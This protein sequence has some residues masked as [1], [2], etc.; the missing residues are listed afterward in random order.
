MEEYVQAYLDA[1]DQ[2]QALTGQARLNAV[3][4]CIAAPRC[5]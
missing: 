4:Y 1:M 2:V 3:G 5:R